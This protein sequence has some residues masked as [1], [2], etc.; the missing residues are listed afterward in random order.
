MRTDAIYQDHRSA[1][2]P[3]PP[4]LPPYKHASMTPGLFMASMPSL[5]ELFRLFLSGKH[6]NRIADPALWAELEKQQEAYSALFSA[7]GYEL[8]TDGRGFAWF[9]TSEAN[10]A[11][12]KTSRQLALLFMVIFEAQANAGKPLMRF[13]DWLIDHDSLREVHGQQ[14]EVLNAEGLTPDGLVD[15][16]NRACSLGFALSEPNGWRLLPAVCRYLDHFEALAA[17]HNEGG[18][19]DDLMELAPLTEELDDEESR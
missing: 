10:S 9:H 8:R 15:L 1:G 5:A 19:G 3:C 16:I 12:S 11:I 13:G 18:G 4:L 2:D 14:Q 17:A 7:L 6:L